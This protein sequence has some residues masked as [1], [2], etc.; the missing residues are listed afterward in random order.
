MEKQD[1]GYLV[2]SPASPYELQCFRVYVPKHTWYIGA[3]WAAYQFFTSWQAWARDPLHRGKIAAALWRTAFEKARAEYNPEGNCEMN[4]TDIRLKPEN[5]C[6][7]QVEY[8]GN[9]VWVDKAD[10]S[11]CGG[12]CSGSGGAIQF[13]GETVNRW[14]ECLQKWTPVAPAFNPST[15]GEYVSTYDDLSGACNGAANIT[16]WIDDMANT[17]LQFMADGAFIGQ[18]G[19]LLVQSMLISVGITPFLTAVVDLFLTEFAEDGAVLGDAATLDVA[20]EF[21]QIL[22][23]YMDADGTIREP[24]F[25]TCVTE[26]YARR[27]EETV[28]TGERVRWGHMANLLSLAGPYVASRNNKWAGITDADC[29]AL[30]WQHV[31]DFSVS[32]QAWYLWD[33]FVGVPSGVYDAGDGWRAAVRLYSGNNQMNLVIRTAFQATTITAIDILYDVEVGVNTIGTAPFIQLFKNADGSPFQ[34]W[35]NLADGDHETKHWS[36]SESMGM[37]SLALTAAADAADPAA[38]GG[39]ALVRKITLRGTGVNPFN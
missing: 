37:L 19:T 18:L 13:D 36:G 12:D 11:K 28:N 20:D 16:A 1:K 22:Y 5:P 30:E 26:L 3:F 10:M 4:I 23:R 34:Q 24:N 9:Q 31:F 25:T 27:D 38:P 39:S 35:S 7:L 29:D 32:K 33:G 15:Q 8:D 17:Q 2:P 14:D 6:I 21:K